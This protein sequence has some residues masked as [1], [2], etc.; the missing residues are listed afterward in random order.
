M[1]R[2]EEDAKAGGTQLD[3]DH[4]R[5]INQNPVIGKSLAIYL[6][7]ELMSRDMVKAK[8]I[9]KTDIEAV[10]ECAHTHK[11]FYDYLHLNCKI[12]AI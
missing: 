6:I 12:P 11:H 7:P 3:L 2:P 1:K 9:I 8:S 5:S 10:V 4:F